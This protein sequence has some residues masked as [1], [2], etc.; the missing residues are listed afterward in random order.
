MGE[1]LNERRQKRVYR[2]PT[3][4]LLPADDLLRTSLQITDASGGDTKDWDIFW[5]S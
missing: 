3:V 2:E 5:H 4:T 1:L